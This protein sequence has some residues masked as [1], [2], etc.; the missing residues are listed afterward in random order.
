MVILMMTIVVMRCEQILRHQVLFVGIKYFHRIY[1][2]FSLYITKMCL[3]SHAPGRK[4]HDV[5]M[6]LQNFG[7]SVGGL[8]TCH[9]S[10]IYCTELTVDLMLIDGHLETI[11]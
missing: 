3:S 6:S 7:P 1:C 2:S 9:T 5:H 4:R 8:A 10:G 11:T